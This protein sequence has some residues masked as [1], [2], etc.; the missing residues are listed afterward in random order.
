MPVGARVLVALDED[1]VVPGDQ[2]PGG[3]IAG[4][5]LLQIEAP[6]LVFVAERRLDG[7]AAE[8]RRHVGPT[9]EPAWKISSM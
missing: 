8:R 3:R 2:E 7:R 6:A 1:R 5:V 9:H 4:E